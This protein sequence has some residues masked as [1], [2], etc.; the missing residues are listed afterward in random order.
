[1]GNGEGK[2]NFFSTC[3]TWWCCFLSQENYYTR[4]CNPRYDVDTSGRHYSGVHE[5]DEK[6]SRE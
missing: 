2:K 5:R 1:V 6:N 3:Q 4:T